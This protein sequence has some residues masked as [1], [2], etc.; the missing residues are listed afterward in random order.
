MIQ[1]PVLS[2]RPKGTSFRKVMAATHVSAATVLG[3]ALRWI[4]LLHR[5]RRATLSLPTMAATRV[6]VMIRGSGCVQR[7]AASSPFALKARCETLATV[8]TRAPAKMEHGVA[9]SPYVSTPTQYA[10]KESP[11]TPRTLASPATAWAEIGIATLCG[12]VEEGMSAHLAA[13]TPMAAI[14]AL[15]TMATFLARIA[16]ARVHVWTAM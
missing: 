9:L 16:T 13:T 8:A 4:A 2:V 11:R 14:V 1:S 6:P 12:T 5:A 15:A 3:H 7:L 10:N